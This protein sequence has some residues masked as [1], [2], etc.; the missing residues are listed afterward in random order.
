MTK[1]DRF[2]LQAERLR[3]VMAMPE[4]EVTIG[5]WIKEALRAANHALHSAQEPIEIY[6]AQGMLSAVKGISEQFD[7]VFDLE[8]AAHAKAAKRKPMETK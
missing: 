1:K 3:A 8:K 4:Y 2:I 6:R 5:E 7:R